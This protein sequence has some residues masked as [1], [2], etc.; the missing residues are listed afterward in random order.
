MGL[1]ASFG[2][3]LGL[4]LSIYLAVN[5]LPDAITDLSNVTLWVDTP[6]VVQTL[7]TVVGPII[8]IAAFIYMLVRAAGVGD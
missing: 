8:A 1:K 2:G 5:M 3:M 6:T 7:A 4:V